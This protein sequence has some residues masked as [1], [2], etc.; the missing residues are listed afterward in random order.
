VPPSVAISNSVKSEIN[1]ITSEIN[2][3]ASTTPTE[4]NV[5]PALASIENR[6]SGLSDQIENITLSCETEKDVLEEK[7]I[8]REMIIGFFIVLVGL[9]LYGRLRGR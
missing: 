3:V 5:G 8:V 2:R 1:A 4:C 7:I 9:Y 6:V